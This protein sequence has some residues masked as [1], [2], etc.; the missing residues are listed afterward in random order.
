MPIRLTPEN[1]REI[2]REEEADLH[3]HAEAIAAYQKARAEK[4]Q[5][6]A[7]RERLAL[8]QDRARARKREE[9]AEKRPRLLGLAAAILLGGIL[10]N[11]VLIVWIASKI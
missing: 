2:F 8:E 5:A 6:K 10:F 11:L 7:E 3:E 9:R 1:F 4:E